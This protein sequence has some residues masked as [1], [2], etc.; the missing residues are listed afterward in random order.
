MKLSVIIPVYNEESTISE[1]IA[2][3]RAV[4]LEKEIIVVDDGSTDR[5][6]QILK[7]EQKKD[8]IIIVYNSLINIGK[9]AA[10]RIGIEHV[11]GALAI[12]QDAD[13]E[14]DP[15]EYGHLI[16]PIIQGRADVVYGSRFQHKSQG[17]LTQIIANKVLTILTNL[18]YHTHLTDMET[19][20]KVFRTDVLKSVK[21]RCTGF[22]FEPEITAKIS[23]LGY[24]ICEV[25]IAYHPRTTEEGKK[26]RWWDGFIAIYCLL[27]Y[28]FQDI[29]N[30]KKIK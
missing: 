24:K 12:I 30:F 16:Q 19:A 18:L 29:K 23:R 27:K 21:L 2:K 3:V 7:D 26:I 14:L 5:T 8:T 28:R 13:L 6:A 9:G 25:P 22:E 11:T 20:Y 10:V 17:S 15:N 4:N 1:V